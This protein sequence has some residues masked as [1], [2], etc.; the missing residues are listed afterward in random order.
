MLVAYCT[1]PSKY[2]TNNFG[3]DVDSTTDFCNTNYTDNVK[4]TGDTDTRTADGISPVAVRH[5][6]ETIS[7]ARQ[8]KKVV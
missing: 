2:H 8:V 6:Q 1:T 5:N 3:A 7:R 4:R